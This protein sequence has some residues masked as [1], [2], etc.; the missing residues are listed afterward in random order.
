[1]ARTRDTIST[2]SESSMSSTDKRKRK[3]LTVYLHD[4]GTPDWDGVTS[5]QR[6]Q[7]GVAGS[8]AGSET[9]AEPLQVPPEMV[10]FLVL[11]L[12]RIESAIV[13]PKI[14]LTSEQTLEVLT[15]APALLQGINEAGARVLA[16]Y[17]GTLGKY[18]DEFMLGSL[19]ITWQA[20]AFAELRRM[21]AANE[22]KREAMPTPIDIRTSVEAPPAGAKPSFGQMMADRK[23][24]AQKPVPAPP[25]APP[26]P[27]EPL[28]DT[29]E[30]GIG[31]KV[32]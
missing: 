5:E 1:M 31:I 26:E 29:E 20:Q 19:L 15:P 28:I 27:V 6:A 3:R 21:C 30:S 22:S 8:E 32:S 18:Q 14:G 9:P 10:G 23:R 12:T 4:D 7:L 13:A 17:G 11:T 2:E 16:K 25:A 24:N